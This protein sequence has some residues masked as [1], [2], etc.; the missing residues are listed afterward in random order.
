MRT[1]IF[2]FLIYL[3]LAVALMVVLSVI[4]DEHMSHRQTRWDERVSEF[5]Q[6]VS[7]RPSER[8]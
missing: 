2:T 3:I 1:R 8:D 4:I 7:L 5:E 6:A